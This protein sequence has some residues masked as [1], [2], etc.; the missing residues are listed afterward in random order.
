MY[1]PGTQ[2]G[3]LQVPYESVSFMA[4]YCLPSTDTLPDSFDTGSES[5]SRA[6]GDLQTA[7]WLIFIMSLVSILVSF[8]YL[9][10]ISIAGRL[11]IV[12]TIL[13]VLVGGITSSWLLIEGGIDN[14]DNSET[15][16]VGKVELV[17]G[18][19]LAVLGV[20]FILALWFM[21]RN[22]ELVIEMLN[23]ASY[24]I[25]DRKWTLMFPIAVSF[26]A[27]GFMAIWI[28]EA[29]FIYSVKQQATY[30]WPTGFFET[31]P[32]YSGTQYFELEFDSA[33]Q[34]SLS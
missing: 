32:F 12:M 28:L 29:L 3:A 9:K 19:V 10:I 7:G 4:S 24:A 34:D 23:E 33:M 26:I 27:I 25:R 8:L 1:I 30:D 2:N 13:T 17:I 22:I 20:V 6:I 5:Y 31:N 15:E 14:M 16:T 18:I 21:R 11:L